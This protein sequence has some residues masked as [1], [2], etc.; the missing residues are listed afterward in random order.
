MRPQDNESSL[1]PESKCKKRLKQRI[2][3]TAGL[4]DFSISPFPFQA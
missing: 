4:G 2:H 3:C 1:A